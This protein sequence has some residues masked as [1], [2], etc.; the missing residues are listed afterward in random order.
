MHLLISTN[1]ID[2][3]KSLKSLQVNPRGLQ[4]STEQFRYMFRA[5]ML[6]V[7]SERN[8]Y[9]SDTF[10]DQCQ[11]TRPR[12]HNKKYSLLM[13]QMLSSGYYFLTDQHSTPEHFRWSAAV[14]FAT[15]TAYVQTNVTGKR[16]FKFSNARSLSKEVRLQCFCYRLNIGLRDILLC[17]RGNWFHK[18]FYQST[19]LKGARQGTE[20]I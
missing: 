4:K 2:Q 18:W 7:I 11:R 6:Q 1:H 13:Q 12:H 5:V 14:P 17:R 15:A 3:S 8:V 16:L 10:A 9:R 19:A 20:L